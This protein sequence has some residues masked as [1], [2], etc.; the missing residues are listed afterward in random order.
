[1]SDEQDKLIHSVNLLDRT[2]EANT[3]DITPTWEG[4]LP[5][6]IEMAA[7]AKIPETR[8]FAFNELLK[9]ARLADSV[10]SANDKLGLKIK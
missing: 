9:L 1:M 3:I 6:L 5:A 2:L 8:K 4:L 10:K 7:N